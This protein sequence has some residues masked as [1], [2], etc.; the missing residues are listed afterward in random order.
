MCRREAATYCRDPLYPFLN[1]QVLDGGAQT[2]AV[3]WNESDPWARAECRLVP[4]ETLVTGDQKYRHVGNIEQQR[5][6]INAAALRY[7]DLSGVTSQSK[8][9]AQCDQLRMPH[10]EERIPMDAACSGK[11]SIGRHTR[12]AF[13]NQM[14]VGCAAP[15]RAWIRAARIAILRLDEHQR[16]RRLASVWTQE[17][18]FTPVVKSTPRI[19]DALQAQLVSPVE[20]RRQPFESGE[21]RLSGFI[22]RKALESVRVGPPLL[23]LSAIAEP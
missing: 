19:A 9:R 8:R 20:R 7:D 16:H 6:D 2:V 12:K 17:A 1:P 10:G 5:V 14:R 23:H 21:G 22:R 11:D 4:R 13:I 18:E 15:Q 3:H